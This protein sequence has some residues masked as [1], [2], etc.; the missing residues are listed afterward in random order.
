MRRS[1]TINVVN[2]S[3]RELTGLNAFSLVSSLSE[4]KDRGARA[5]AVNLGVV[6]YI[7]EPGVDALI[8]GE[9]IFGADNF[10][11][12]N[13]Q[14]TPRQFV[15]EHAPGRFRIYDSKGAAVAALRR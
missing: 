5:V 7:T 11:V 2:V 10:V 13:L 8:Q 4:A 6:T 12:F 3:G 14:G 9:K 15:E 1:G